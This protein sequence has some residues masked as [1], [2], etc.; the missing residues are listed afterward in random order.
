MERAMSACPRGSFAFAQPLAEGFGR[1]RARLAAEIDGWGLQTAQIAVAGGVIG[2]AGLELWRDGR[3]A[4]FL[5]LAGGIALALAAMR[6]ETPA[7][8]DAHVAPVAAEDRPPAH[9]AL[10]SEIALQLTAQRQHGRPDP[11]S[12]NLSSQAWCELMAR[13]SHD[14]R[15]PLNAV[16]GFSDV[17][18]SELFGP[19]GDDRYREYIAHIRD[20]GRE[21]LKSAED[22]LAIT[23]LLGQGTAAQRGQVLHLETL[24]REAAAARGLDTLKFDVEAGLEVIGETRPL[25]QVLVNLMAEAAFRSGHGGQARLHAQAEDEFVIV[26]MMVTGGITRP[27]TQESSLHMCMARVLLELGGGR[28]IEI[29]RDGVWRA[30]TVLG[31]AAQQDFFCGHAQPAALRDVRCGGGHRLAS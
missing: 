16:I 14:L 10:Q 9:L 7:G 27:G 4:T 26:Q 11:A 2:L 22:T 12:V 21:L 23:S 28:L 18:T 30:V 24:A 20:S 13:V 5:L 15:T 17:M 1:L 19:V 25:R 3:T 31:R 6:Q 8:R 29:E